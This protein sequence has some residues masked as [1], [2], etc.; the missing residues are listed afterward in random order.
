MA[1]VLTSIS[2]GKNRNISIYSYYCYDMYDYLYNN[3]NYYYDTGLN[4]ECSDLGLSWQ[5]NQ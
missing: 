1:N 5:N 4:I 2:T 3:N